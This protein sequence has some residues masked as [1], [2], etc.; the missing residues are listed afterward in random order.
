MGTITVAWRQTALQTWRGSAKVF[1]FL[2]SVSLAYIVPHL[3]CFLGISMS[4]LVLQN[5]F[6]QTLRFVGFPMVFLYCPRELEQYPAILTEL[7]WS[8]KHLLHGIK[9]TEKMIFQLVYFRH[10]ASVNSNCTLPPHG[11]I[12]GNLPSFYYGLQIVGDRGN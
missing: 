5:P 8:I 4:P 12:S 9:N 10:C 2:S 7:A 6:S 11:L 3:L 1:G